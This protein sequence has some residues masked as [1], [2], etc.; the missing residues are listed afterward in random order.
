M[1]VLLCQLNPVVGDVEGN[2]GLL[3]QAFEGA[4]GR[5]DLVVF[6]ELFLTGYPPRDLLEYPS[7]IDKVERAL[8][9]AATITARFPQTGLLVGAPVRTGKKTGRGLYNA[10]ILFCNGREVF[11]QAKSLLP[12]YDVFDEIRYFDPAPQVSTVDFRGERL[13]ISVCE[14]AWNAPEMWGRHLYDFD[15]MAEAARQ[16]ATLLVNVSASPFTV[17]KDEARRQLVSGHA[18]RHGLPFIFVNQVGANDE[19]V[20][21]G[22]SLAFD[23]QGEPLAVLGQF[24][25]EQRMVD[26]ATAGDPARYQPAERIASVH[27]GLVL[28]IHDY[29]GKCGFK[30]VVLGLSGGIDSAVT[31]ALAVAAL[32]PENVM[33]VTMP[34][35]FSS[36]GSVDDSVALA[37]NLG[38]ELRQVSIG[39]VYHSY[40]SL[41]E[42]EFKGMKPDITEENIQARVRGNVLMAFSSKQGR[43]VLTTGNKSELA[44]GYCTLYGDMSGGLCVLADV[45]K[46]MVYE[47]AHYINR[48]R[49]IIPTATIAKP[50][51]AELRPNQ[52]DQDTLPP[53]DVLD[54]IVD[55]YVEDAQSAD[56][57]VQAGFD[58]KMVEW[59][60]RA[61]NRTEYK[62]RQAAPGIK[63]TSKAF[64]MGRRMPVAGRY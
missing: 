15:P 24:T 44:V 57:I 35:E 19:L 46:T 1:K 52:T 6:P 58:R 7:F 9:E 32:G 23:R 47:L 51:S 8:A 49:E 37:R 18:R 5:P 61:V 56:V 60:I 64:G 31:C 38:V 53:Y 48:E 25:G 29:I 42:P 33:G 4:A 11:R 45:P 30:Q 2:L 3:R 27:G 10:A 63:V 41:L 36:R 12:N 55:R 39:E 43:M 50:P 21:D 40:L 13:G 16:G 26:T 62:R 34:S 59:V 22:R 20:F 17:G 28:G 54:S 14:D